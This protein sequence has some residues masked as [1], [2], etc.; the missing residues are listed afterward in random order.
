[1]ELLFFHYLSMY[2]QEQAF[3]IF[4]PENT[5]E[6][7]TITSSEKNDQEVRITL[8]EKN[9]PPTTN[10]HAG[11]H[12]ECAGMKDISIED[13]PVRG[14]KTILIFRRRYWKVAGEKKLLK[15][16]MT[17]VAAG[18]KIE[19]EFAAFLKEGDRDQGLTCYDYCQCLPDGGEETYAQLQKASQ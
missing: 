14:R 17:L 6:W 11:K 16:E 13:F 1:M 5:L 3:S 15:R 10:L 4:L 8:E 19:K 9:I 7:F 12:I 2:I 18:T